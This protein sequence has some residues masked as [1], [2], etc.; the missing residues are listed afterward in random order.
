MI[1]SVALILIGV[2]LLFNPNLSMDLVYYILGGILMVY[3][4]IRIVG[5]FS[6][7]LYQLA[8]QYDL[9]FGILMIA[10]GIVMVFQAFG[11]E[12]QVHV[13]YGTLILTDSLY[14]IQVAIDSK[15]FGIENWGLM[16]VLAIITGVL[17]MAL[18]VWSPLE[19]REAV[20]MVGLASLFEGLMCLDV[21]MS[22]V[23]VA[24]NQRFD[25]ER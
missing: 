16:I 4:L 25:T 14:K 11:I 1:T 23:K 9:A 20:V 13:I 10:L 21:S 17:G 18:I 22:V 5:Y 6:R 3:G 2:R 8:F 15:R 7:D 19:F 12:E 24:Q